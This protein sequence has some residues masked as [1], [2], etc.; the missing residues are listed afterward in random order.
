MQSIW[1]E[2]VLRE[3]SGE[4]TAAELLRDAETA[5]PPV[6]DDEAEEDE[7]PVSAR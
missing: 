2:L 7:Q 3:M 5:Q 1:Y 4:D 6:V